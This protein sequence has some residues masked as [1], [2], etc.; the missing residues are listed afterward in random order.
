MNHCHGELGL[1]V[2][3]VR[4]QIRSEPVQLRIRQ[5][6][7]R[8]RNRIVRVINVVGIQHDEMQRTYVQRECISAHPVAHV[9][10]R[11]ARSEIGRIDVENACHQIKFIAGV[12]VGRFVITRRSDHGIL[13]H[14]IR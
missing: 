2:C 10:F 3:K 14:D 9:R 5:T 4:F 13:E 8:G 7:R 1:V 12:I 6:L 11:G